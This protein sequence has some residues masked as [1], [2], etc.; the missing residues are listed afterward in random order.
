MESHGIGVS[1]V[2]SFIKIIAKKR[3]QG[4]SNYIR[5]ATMLKEGKASK[6]VN[7]SVFSLKNA[8]PVREL[9]FS[10]IDN[11]SGVL[12]SDLALLD[13]DSNEN[14]II[15]I[16]N[17]L[18][19][20][21][22]E[23]QLDAYQKRTDIKFKRCKVREFVYL[24]LDGREPFIHSDSAAEL[25]SNKHW[26]TLSWIN[27]ILPLLEK[28][29]PSKT[30][31]SLK[32]TI[33]ILNDIKNISDKRG[34][35]H[36]ETTKE[37]ILEVVSDC[38]LEELNRLDK[39]EGSSWSKTKVAKNKVTLNYSK[40]S[41]TELVL[42]LLPDLSI[43]AHSERNTTAISE[44]LYLPLN[45]HPS[46]ILNFIDLFAREIYYSYFGNQTMEYLSSRRRKTSSRSKTQEVAFD[47]LQGILKDYSK[48]RMQSM[49]QRY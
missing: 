30:K 15:I 29:A 42:K 24:T 21:N 18:F 13:L 23:G 38:L 31:G 46:Q 2:K 28:L 7:T 1:F 35:S 11:K 43:T 19:G 10:P 22:R 40:Y 17:K 27:D 47:I 44:K 36:I 6:G 34:W 25:K 16:E 9:Y 14:L 33:K 8:S 49:M 37:Q 5:K 48:L 39:K 12:F 20:N 32:K 26:V 45:I 4:K 3:S 41:A